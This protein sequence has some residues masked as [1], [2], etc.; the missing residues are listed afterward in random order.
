MPD[1][2]QKSLFYI[3]KNINY[4]ENLA[5][6]Y[7]YKHFIGID[8]A[9]RGPI[10]G[11]VVVAGVYLLRDIE[12]LND[13]KKLNEKK[14]VELFDKIKKNSLYSVKTINCK[15]IDEINILQAT[16]RGMVEVSEELLKL[17]PKINLLLIDGNQ[18]IDF[19]LEQFA[20]VK[21]DSLSNS[22]AAASI[23]A[24][25]TRDNIMLEY[26]KKYPCYGFEK[27]KG[28]PTKEH[29]ARLKECGICDIHRRSFAPV[30]NYLNITV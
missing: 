29:I 13:S 25:V 8:E 16:K 9:G 15:T 20:I 28:Y 18:K 5:K 21:G 6:F 10:A 27:H 23:L 2:Y 19:P 12:G 26:S 3:E 7:G 4:G 17:N 1:K 14:R 11:P 24:K 22:I 30:K